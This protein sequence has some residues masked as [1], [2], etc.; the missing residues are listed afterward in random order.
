MIG[1]ELILIPLTII[2]LTYVLKAHFPFAPAAG[3]PFNL[4]T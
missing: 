2:P 3:W 4:R 1:N